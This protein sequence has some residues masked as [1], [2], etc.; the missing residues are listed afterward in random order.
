MKCSR[1]VGEESSGKHNNKR[2]CEEDAEEEVI[3]VFAL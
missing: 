3:G 1:N 2:R